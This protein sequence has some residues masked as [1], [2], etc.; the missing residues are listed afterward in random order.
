[1][2]NVKT[3]CIGKWRRGASHPPYDTGGGIEPPLESDA[4]NNQ[5]G[6]CEFCI[7]PGAANALHSC[8]PNCHSLA[9]FDADLHLVIEA[10][11][12]LSDAI[13]RAVIGLVRSQE[14][15]EL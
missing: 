7:D 4:T 10:W 8:G 1:M 6:G 15:G 5:P 12:G 3:D 9:A 14:G 11:E 13:R 2:S